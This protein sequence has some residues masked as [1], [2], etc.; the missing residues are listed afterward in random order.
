MKFW[1]LIMNKEKGQS[2]V[3]MAII[4]PLLIFLMIGVFEVGWALRSYL[5]LIN[6]NREAAR[7]AV[8]PYYL[9]FD[10]AVD[11]GWNTV[12]TQALISEGEMLDIDFKDKGTMV[13]AYLEVNTGE[14]C[15]ENLDKNN[16]CDCLNVYTATIK[17]PRTNPTFTIT[18]GPSQT[19]H[20]D[21]EM[22]ATE[23]ALNNRIKNCDFVRKGFAAKGDGM[24]IVEMWFQQ[25]QL[26]GFPLISN[27]FTDP[28]PMYAH[29]IMRKIQAVRGTGQAEPTVE[30]TI[31]P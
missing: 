19:T 20:F 30:P 17:I 13:M 22:I 10:D 28:V 14:A 4:T 8:R 7:F 6:I 12:L 29:T 15:N 5:V 2:L 24:V 9:N 25:P 27:P 21:Y 26:L 1:N 18:Y 23:L 31:E 16:T 11:P 3:E